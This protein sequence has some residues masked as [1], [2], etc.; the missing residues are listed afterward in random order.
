VL[1]EKGKAKVE[2]LKV[3]N[4]VERSAVRIEKSKLENME[5]PGNN[6]DKIQDKK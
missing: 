5:T 3:N 4:K 6:T 1:A 2:T